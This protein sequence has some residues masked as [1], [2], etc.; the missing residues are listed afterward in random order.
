MKAIILAAGQGTRLSPL[1]DRKPKCLVE[2]SGKPLLE[3]QLDTLRACG[4][5]D[6]HIVDGYCVDQLRQYDIKLHLN[7]RYAEAN[8]VNTLFA[9]EE[10]MTGNMDL[11]IAYG[12]I[13]YESRVLRALLDCDVPIALAVDREWHRYWSARM[14]SPL[15]DAETWKL[16]NGNRITELG[17]KL[18]DLEKNLEA[19]KIFR[20]NTLD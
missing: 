10:V 9:A 1:T 14:D 11:F 2:L 17:K 20:A 8:M 16:T 18:R 6:I 4:I 19:S 3:Y 13:V 12:H 15:S 5:N 7:P